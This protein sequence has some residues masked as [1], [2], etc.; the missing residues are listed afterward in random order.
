MRAAEIDLRAKRQARQ[1]AEAAL[2]AERQA[3]RKAEADLLADRQ[4]RQE[5]E[6]RIPELEARIEVLLRRRAPD[7]PLPIAPASK[8]VDRSPV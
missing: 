3:W 5:A 6:A 1:E 2:R 7:S 4:A 8:S